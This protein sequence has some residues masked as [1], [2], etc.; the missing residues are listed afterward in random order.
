MFKTVLRADQPKGERIAPAPTSAMERIRGFDWKLPEL[1][2]NERVELPCSF[3]GSISEEVTAHSPIDANQFF[4]VGT[5]TGGLFQIN[6]STGQIQLAV[7]AHEASVTSIHL[8]PDQQTVFS[9]SVDGRICAWNQ[10]LEQTMEFELNATQ[11][12]CAVHPRGHLAVSGGFDGK[13]HVWDLVRQRLLA[14]LRGHPDAIISCDFFENGLLAVGGVNGNF[15]IWELDAKRMLRQ[16]Q[17]DQSAITGILTNPDGSYVTLSAS[18]RMR[19]FNQQHRARLEIDS[20]PTNAYSLSSSR[21]QKCLFTAHSSGMFGVFR[22]DS[23][24]NIDIIDAQLGPIATVVPFVEGKSIFV[25]AKDGRLKRYNFDDLGVVRFTNRHDGDVYQLQ[26]TPDNLEMFSAGH[27]GLLRVWDRITTEETECVDLKTGPITAFAFSDDGN[28]WSW[29][30]ANGWVRLWDVA[31][32]E[33]AASWQAHITTVSCLKFLPRSSYF[34]SGGWDMKLHLWH[35]DHRKPLIT[36]EGHT[37]EVADC[38][39]T[40]DARRL[41]SVAW[42]GTARLWELSFDRNRSIKEVMRYD[43]QGMQFHCC[44]IRP[45]GEVFATG[46][47][48]GVLRIWSVN[49]V[50]DPIELLGDHSDLTCCKFSTDGEVLFAADRMGVV[51]A[52]S[53]QCF[54]LLARLET[55]RPILSIAVSHDNT[56]LAIGDQTGRARMIALDYHAGD[57]WLAASTTLKEAPIWLRGMPPTE[58]HQLQCLYCG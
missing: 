52:W 18:G 35:R 49:R 30:S 31:D 54:K 33:I 42:D 40:L 13:L 28:Q 4:Y 6:A 56:Q 15:S 44:S 23:F 37:K 26:F 55:G 53:A 46:A 57:L 41:L 14:E 16:L 58:E 12:T 19:L 17:I 38:D 48:D 34:V 11:Q 9:T 22:L 51:T 47:A 25:V 1:L 8:A 5:V 2:P 45:D 29:G 27:D 43:Q 20:L 24:E 10:S 32:N 7:Q 39:I 21:G 3:L 50:D 36:F